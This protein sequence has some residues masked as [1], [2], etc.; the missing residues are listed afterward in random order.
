MATIQAAKKMPGNSQLHTTGRRPT[1]AGD[2][3]HDANRQRPLHSLPISA[4]DGLP[5][6]RR[7]TPI[8]K[9]MGLITGTKTALK[10]G[11]RP[12][13]CQRPGRQSNKGIER[14]EAAR[15]RRQRPAARCW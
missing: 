15:W 5:A 12:K 9:R 4:T 7:A 11:G 13:S 2:G 14:A 1:A 3:Y 10:Y 8:R 6:G